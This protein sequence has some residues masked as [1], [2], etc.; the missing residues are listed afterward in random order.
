LQ[1][2]IRKLVSWQS[3]KA[4]RLKILTLRQAQDDSYS[5][6]CREII[7]IIPDNRNGWKIKR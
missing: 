7:T 1:V 6:F 2:I 5:D 4:L 3:Q